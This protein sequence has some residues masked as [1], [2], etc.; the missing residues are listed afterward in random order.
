[1]FVQALIQEPSGPM[2]Y[3]RGVPVFLVL[4]LL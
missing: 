1:M 3:R 2:K 4:A